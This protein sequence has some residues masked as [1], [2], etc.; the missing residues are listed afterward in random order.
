M[1]KGFVFIETIIVL[2]IV[3]MSLT[4]LFASYTL[5]KTKSQEKENYDKIS[6]KYLLYAISNLGTNATFN[7][8]TLADHGN[9]VVTPRTCSSYTGLIYTN[10]F[11]K[12]TYQKNV[13]GTTKDV[14][15]ED[16][17]FDKCN[18]TNQDILAK[19]NLCQSYYNIF[20]PRATQKVQINT[21]SFTKDDTTM[22]NCQKVLTELNVVHL[23]VINDVTAALKSPNA[24]K[25]YDNGTINYLKTLRKCYDTKYASEHGMVLDDVKDCEAPVRYLVGVFSRYG[26]Y[27]FASI[28]I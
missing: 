28:E 25:I 16:F 7:Y 20:S 26:E 10:N 11:E 27:F 23:Y 15:C 2:M 8:G 14:G 5:I 1:K 18:T 19:C 24:T 22:P 12:F 21:S 3:T 17:V 13:G 4:L 6:D 9:L